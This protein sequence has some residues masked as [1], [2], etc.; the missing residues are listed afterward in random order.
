MERSLSD[1]FTDFHTVQAQAYLDSLKNM[2]LK[3]LMVDKTIATSK[4]ENKIGIILHFLD[5]PKTTIR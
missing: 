5:E 1:H 3:K 2:V 4:I